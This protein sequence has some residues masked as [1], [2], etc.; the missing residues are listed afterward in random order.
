MTRPDAAKLRRQ[1]RMQGY[2]DG[3]QGRS[4]RTA[5]LEYQRAWKRGREAAAA[6]GTGARCVRCGRP[7][8]DKC[9]CLLP[10]GGAA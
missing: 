4:A 10:Q 5:H 3:Y 9:R 7:F 1:L 8:P 6:E 2:N